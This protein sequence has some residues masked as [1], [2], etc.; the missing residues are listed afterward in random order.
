MRSVTKLHAP[1]KAKTATSVVQLPPPITR[2][3]TTAA[4]AVSMSFTVEW[5]VSGLDDIVSEHSVIGLLLWLARRSGTHW[6]MNCELTL[7]IGL[8]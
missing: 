4:V 2:A 5:Q 7:V 8:N 6:Q 1:I 3:T